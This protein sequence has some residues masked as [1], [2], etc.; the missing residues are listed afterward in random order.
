[1]PY[2]GRIQIVSLTE[3]DE[4]TLGRM[5]SDLLRAE[6][7]FDDPLSDNSI[8]LRSIM[9]QIVESNGLEVGTWRG[10]M[11]GVHGREKREERRRG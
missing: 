6:A 9:E 4:N 2:T 8:T 3:K 5:T 1:M 7:V 10:N 11:S